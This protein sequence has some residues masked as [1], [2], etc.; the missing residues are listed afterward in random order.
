MN[1]FR[2]FGLNIKVVLKCLVLVLFHLFHGSMPIRLTDH[3]YWGI[4]IVERNAATCVHSRCYGESPYVCLVRKVNKF[5]GL[6][7]L[8]Q[9][10]KCIDYRAFIKFSDLIPKSEY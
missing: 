1:Y 8:N 10:E 3:K 2:H 6:V 7:E 9:C 4:G 5:P